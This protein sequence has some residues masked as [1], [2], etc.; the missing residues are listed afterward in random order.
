MI[1]LENSFGALKLIFSYDEQSGAEL[2][3]IDGEN[4]RHLFLARRSAENEKFLF[5][6]LKDSFLYEYET[7][8]IGKK[9]ATLRLI[10]SFEEPQETK[11]EREIAW[12]VVDPKTIEKTLPALNELG[13]DNIHF[14]YSARSQKNFKIDIERINRIL[15]N[16]CCQ[17]GRTKLM[18][19]HT[20]KNIEEF[21]NEKKEFFVL[22]FGGEP[23]GDIKEG[24]FLIGPEGG[25]TNDEKDFLKSKAQ[26]VVSFFGANV[27]KSETAAI[28]VASLCAM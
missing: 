3:K 27:L 23:F 8:N 18:G 28:A 13:I 12:C 11:R 7:S 10:N 17:C 22:D 2:L 16:S 9:E 19:V 24:L 21:C 26:K 6:N 20:F 1:L 4:F 15:I 14:I 25:F 5:R